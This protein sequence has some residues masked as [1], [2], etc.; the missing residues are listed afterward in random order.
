MSIRH[1][2]YVDTI[3]RCRVLLTFSLEF[4]V[5]I[6]FG[7]PLS[8]FFLISRRYRRRQRRVE[9]LSSFFFWAQKRFYDHPHRWIWMD[10]WMDATYKLPSYSTYLLGFG[11][12]RPFFHSLFFCCHKKKRTKIVETPSAYPQHYYN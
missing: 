1:K 12:V 11:T 7:R 4:E 5:S 2:C 8:F 9:V 3:Y 6:K 10:G